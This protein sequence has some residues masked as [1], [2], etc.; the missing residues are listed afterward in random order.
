MLDNETITSKTSLLRLKLRLQKGC[1]MAA[2]LLGSR[3][4]TTFL[5][6][7]RLVEIFMIFFTWNG[8]QFSSYF[9]L[10]QEAADTRDCEAA[11]LA[12]Q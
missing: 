1:Q 7:A 2:D 12:L 10:C 6:S 11:W 3:I 8:I 5:V 4:V 9:R